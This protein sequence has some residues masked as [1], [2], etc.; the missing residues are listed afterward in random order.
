[1]RAGP[2]AIGL[3]LLAALI[4]TYG[5]GLWGG[6]TSYRYRMTVHVDTPA[7]PRS[8]SSV[9]EVAYAPSGPLSAAAFRQEIRGEAVAVDLPGGATLFALL[10]SHE[11][12][13]SGAGH[14]APWAYARAL[15]YGYDWKEGVE[16]LVRQTEPAVLPAEHV[17]TLI[18]FRNP[19]DARTIEVLDPSDLEAS[20]GPGTRLDRVEIRIT[21]DPVTSADRGR[22]PDLGEGSGFHEWANGLHRDDRRKIYRSDYRSGI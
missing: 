5:C 13:E 3:L 15:P 1:M 4:V 18:R 11:D 10:S 6:W 19:R 7:G 14:Y 16:I 17:P 22:L 2:W 20:F 21:Q 9:I 12:R 8:G